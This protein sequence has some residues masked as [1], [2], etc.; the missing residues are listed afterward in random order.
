VSQ[1]DK[2]R[3]GYMSESVVEGIVK[4]WF[5]TPSGAYTGLIES[6]DGGLYIASG[7]NF[8][9]KVALPHI[10][11]GTHVCFVPSKRGESTADDARVKFAWGVAHEISTI[12]QMN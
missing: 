7:I 4:E 2:K 12:P 1:C 8:T 3:G 9:D 5:T 11:P 6:E 10:R